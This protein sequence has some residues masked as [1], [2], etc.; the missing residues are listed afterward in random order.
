MKGAFAFQ[1]TG[2][3]FSKISQDQVHKQNNEVI[4]GLGEATP[5]LNRVYDSGLMR[6]E[7]GGTEVA[8]LLN[9]FEMT[10]LRISVMSLENTTR[11]RQPFTKD[12]CHVRKL[13]SC[14]PC[15]LFELHDLLKINYTDVR[16]GTD[17]YEALK[18]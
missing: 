7:L 12:S 6:C 4:K 8:C 18:S 11:I 13:E 16:Y 15:N 17:V 3:K 5:F 10:S 9:E 1:K 14:F 2:R